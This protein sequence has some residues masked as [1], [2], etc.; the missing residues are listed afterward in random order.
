MDK[1]YIYFPSCNFTRM[2]PETSKAMKA[3]L[4]DRGVEVTAC[5]RVS[6]Q[7]IDEATQKPL[8]ICQTCQMIIAENHPDDL[9]KS[10]FIYLDSLE[11]VSWP[12]HNGETITVQDCF[13][14]LD[15]EHEMTPIDHIAERAAIRSLLKKM[16][17]N[18]IELPGEKEELLFDS[19]MPTPRLAGNGKFAPKAF[20][21]LGKHHFS[22][23]PDAPVC[24][25]GPSLAEYGERFTSDVV[26]YCNNC[27]KMLYDAMPDGSLTAYHLAELLM[28]T[29]G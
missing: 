8:I 15:D 19:N 22:D 13:K 21:A 1:K 17:Y 25:D 4:S 10:V 23:A 12:D 27:M 3:F 29:K 28:G 14:A 5:C 9:P 20:E 18:V 24:E 26:G 7:K 6:H 16:N 11:D 2:F